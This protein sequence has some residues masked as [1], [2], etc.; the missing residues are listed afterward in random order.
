M[1][2]RNRFLAL[3]ALLTGATLALAGFACSP[4]RVAGGGSD[5]E[6]SGRIVT[7]DGKGNPG[8]RVSLVPR[9]HNPAFD[10]Q[11]SRNMLE[12]T[13]SDGRY[14]FTGIAPGSYNVQA[15]NNAQDRAVLRMGITV[16]ETPVIVPADSL[17]ATAAIVI[18]LPDSMENSSGYVYVVGTTLCRQIAAGA[19]AVELVSVPQCTLP[20][21]KFQRSALDSAVVLAANLPVNSPDTIVLDPFASWSHSAKITINTSAAGAATSVS[22]THFP[23]AVR[24]NASNFNFSQALPGGKDLRFSKA[25]GRPCAFEIVEW[26]SVLDQAVVWI[27]ID[28]V[29]GN[30]A[31]QFVRMHWGNAAALPASNPNAVFDTAYGFAAVWHLEEE[32]AGIGNPG[33][34]KDATPN[35]ADGDDYISSTS[36]AGVVANG[37]GF[38]GTDKV[39]TNSGVTEMAAGDVTIAAWVNLSAPGG[40][41]LAKGK[42]NIVQN[43]GEKQLY[44]SDGTPAGGT[45][46]RPSFFGKGNGYAFADK[47]VPLD[48]QWHFLVFR[49]QYESGTAGTASFFLDGAQTG[50]TSTYT[51]GAKDNVDDKV[52]IGY[53]GIQYLTGS[54]DEVHVSKTARSSDWLLLSY[55]NQRSDQKV[56]IVTQEK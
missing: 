50:I 21:V 48:N 30:N 19:D 17:R 41:L 36:Q 27:S 6:V 35:A 52:T 49:W 56:V 13:D 32:K 39:S 38:G 29:Y 42:E 3:R 46:L 8:A 37:H 7:V 22:L 14:R 1:K 10:S 31:S 5:T 28:T 44:F 12:V 16:N 18:P 24:L 53:N 23:V 25:S 26:D 40:V 33:L 2:T 4:T 47:D 11:T 45:G 54:L 20:E 55:E 9:T 34:Y 15:V 43:T 51:A